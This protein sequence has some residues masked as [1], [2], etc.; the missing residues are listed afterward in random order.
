MSAMFRA[1][2]DIERKSTKR[3]KDDEGS[4]AFHLH[5]MLLNGAQATG[6]LIENS[7]HGYIILD[8]LNSDEPQ[9]IA[10]DHISVVE[11]EWM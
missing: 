7:T 1:I 4:S 5:V 10:H 9:Y 8:N 11:P 3:D 2:Q 6:A